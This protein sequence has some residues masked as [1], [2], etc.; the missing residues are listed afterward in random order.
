MQTKRLLMYC[1]GSDS[2]CADAYAGGFH[3]LDATALLAEHHSRVP[4]LFAVPALPALVEVDHAW[5]I[6]AYSYP[7]KCEDVTR[8]MLAEWSTEAS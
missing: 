6:V 1:D 4:A 3:N 7:N 5:G 2:G 8:R